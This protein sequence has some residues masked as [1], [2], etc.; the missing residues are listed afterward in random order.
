MN[1]V[2]KTLGYPIYFGNSGLSA[3]AKL[4]EKKPG[5]LILLGDEN[6]IKHCLPELFMLNE[7]LF[8]GL[9]FIEVP[10]GENSKNIATANDIWQSLLESNIDRDGI[11]IN[12]GGGMITDLGGFAAAAFKRGI[13]FVNIPT[14][15][16]AMVDASVG[17]KTAVNLGHHKNQIGFFAA[18]EMVLI[19][20]QFLATLP[21]RELLSGKV[22][23]IK[24]ALIADETLLT[25][26]F[27]N[28]PM[29][30][31]E[32]IQSIEIKAKI[33]KEDPKE[34]GIRKSLNAGH[35]IG[36]AIEAYSH[37]TMEHPLLH[38]EAIAIGLICELHLSL[39]RNLI[40]P[41]NFSQLVALLLNHSNNFRFEE[42]AFQQLI[43]YIRTDKKNSADALLFSLIGPLG[44][45]N[46][47]IEITEDEI[48]S[49]LRYFCTIHQN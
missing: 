34:K 33:V 30:M 2:N 17:N 26:L 8:D 6:T 4:V 1:R 47:N 10:A 5:K 7:T 44:N 21:E 45:C 16:L 15:L 14:S 29:G 24:H 39:Q 49:A 28:K 48:I 18:P 40:S 25:A 36:H 23:H 19:L 43:T 3:L 31:E 11:L 13:R 42:S 46:I 22:E 20:P 12:L 37:E 38:G 9:E 41:E 32:I 35:T 27:K